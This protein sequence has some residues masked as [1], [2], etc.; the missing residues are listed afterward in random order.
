MSA[1]SRPT[2]D[3]ARQMLKDWN[4]TVSSSSEPVSE[5]TTF[6]QA[7]LRSRDMMADVEELKNV[8]LEAKARLAQA[9]PPAP[10]SGCTSSRDKK[11]CPQ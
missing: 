6:E 9:A 1:S 8:F 5:I 7:R 2:R 4:L 10:A 3:I 11:P